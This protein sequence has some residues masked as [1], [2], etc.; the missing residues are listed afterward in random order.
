MKI[1]RKAC[2]INLVQEIENFS[3]VIGFEVF[4]KMSEQLENKLWIEIYFV[5]GIKKDLRVIIIQFQGRIGFKF[6]IFFFG[7][8]V[9]RNKKN[10]IKF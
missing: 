6:D 2:S 7:N 3:Y 1:L 8:Y 4:S 10:K 9:Y 5:L